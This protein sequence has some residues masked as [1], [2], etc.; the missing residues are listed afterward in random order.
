M[1]TLERQLAAVL[2]QIKATDTQYDAR[3]RLVYKALALAAELGYPCGIRYDAAEG[4]GWPVVSITL[5]GAGEVS[6]HCAAA[7]AVYD[8]YDTAEKYRRAWVYAAC[9][10]VLF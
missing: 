4:T 8:G 1:E 10:G 7:T 6:W 5:P 2:K 3:T 9:H